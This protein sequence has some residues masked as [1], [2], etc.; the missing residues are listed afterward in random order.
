MKRPFRK[1]PTRREIL[2]GMKVLGDFTAAAYGRAPSTIVVP[3]KRDR[4]RR[5]SDGKPVGPTEHQEQCAVIQWWGHAHH[6]YQLPVFALFAIPN[7]G[8]RDVITGA[9][10]K[11]EGVRRGAF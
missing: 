11:A 1:Q 9:R 3:P 5:P 4:I 8:A 6:S 7:G 2:E 10:L